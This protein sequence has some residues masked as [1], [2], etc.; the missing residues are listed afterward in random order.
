MS[1]CAI[2]TRASS[3]R[4]ATLTPAWL[5]REPRERRA[6]WRWPSLHGPPRRALSGRRTPK[7]PRS[8]HVDAQGVP[9]QR[10]R[11]VDTG[12]WSWWPTHSDSDDR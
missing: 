1:R 2:F 6:R 4:R 8:S 12:A 11:Q 3:A 9:S 10:H 5:P 7:K